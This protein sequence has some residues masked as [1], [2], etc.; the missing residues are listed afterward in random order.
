MKIKTTIMTVFGLA[1]CYKIFQNVTIPVKGLIIVGLVILVYRLVT[2]EPVSRF[3]FQPGPLR[4]PVEPVPDLIADLS[5]DDPPT[6]AAINRVRD[7]FQTETRDEAAVRIG[8]EGES[9]VDAMLAGL[10]QPFLSNLYLED[11]QGLTQVDHVVKMPWGIVVIETKNY[12]GFISGTKDPKRWKQSFRQYGSD[13]YYLFQNPLHQNYRHLHAVCHVSGLKEHV[14]SVVVFAGK[15]RTSRRVHDQIVRLPRL[16]S[17]LYAR[18]NV[19]F[20]SDERL[21][22]AWKRLQQQAGDN[23][24]RGA[25]HRIDLQMRH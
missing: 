10:K 9:R 7:G 18:P 23:R 14:F 25:E 13:T 8:Q 2:K 5:D 6:N 3:S 17:C 15:A 22:A 1:I 16:R 4:R 20:I 24:H 12:G 19:G 21:D 11:D